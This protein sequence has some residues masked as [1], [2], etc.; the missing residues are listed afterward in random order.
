[1]VHG[2]VNQRGHQ[3]SIVKGRLSSS[4][5]K[6]YFRYADPPRDSSFLFVMIYQTAQTLILEHADIEFRRINVAPRR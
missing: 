3:P 2:L 4:I 5:Q 6:P 1:M